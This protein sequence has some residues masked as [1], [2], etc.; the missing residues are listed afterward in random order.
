MS[1]SPPSP[2]GIDETKGALSA[3]V[4]QNLDSAARPPSSPPSMSPW[5]STTAFIA[6]ALVP[7]TPSKVRHPSSSR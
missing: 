7:L 1:G 4:F 2:V 5:A 3:T 6:P